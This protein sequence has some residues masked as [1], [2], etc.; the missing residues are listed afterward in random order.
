MPLPRT[1][2]ACCGLLEKGT[3]QKGKWRM[4][5]N[6]GPRLCT[7]SPFSNSDSESRATSRY[8]VRYFLEKVVARGRSWHFRRSLVVAQR[9]VVNMSW[10]F[11]DISKLFRG[12]F[13]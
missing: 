13:F 12:R 3:H 6:A 9:T 8:V 1:G 10:H 7:R 4:E 2:I 11:E 5:P